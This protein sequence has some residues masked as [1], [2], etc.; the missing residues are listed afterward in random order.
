MNNFEIIDEKGV[1]EDGLYDFEEAMAS[2]ESL[3][4]ENFEF[5]GDIKIVEV[6]YL[7]R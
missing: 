6:H 3:M 2:L 5:E 7:T 4:Q 1:I